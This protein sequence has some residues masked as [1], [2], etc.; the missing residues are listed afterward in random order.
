M[1]NNRKRTAGQQKAMRRFRFVLLILSVLIVVSFIISMNT[2]YIKLT[3]VEVF[4]T[5]FGYGT[6]QQSLILFEFLALLR[7]CIYHRFLICGY[8]CVCVYQIILNCCSLK[9]R[10]VLPFPLHSHLFFDVMFY[11]LCVCI[12]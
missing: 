10:C 12:P 2:G 5:L 6:D 3:P 1:K 8:V 4:K 11:I 9:F 7:V